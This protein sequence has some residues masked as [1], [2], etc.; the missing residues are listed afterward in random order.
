[1]KNCKLFIKLLCTHK[2]KLFNFEKLG[3]VGLYIILE[4]YQKI[5]LMDRHQKYFL[6]TYSILD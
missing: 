6:N 3:H 4:K 1:M 2:F 5:I